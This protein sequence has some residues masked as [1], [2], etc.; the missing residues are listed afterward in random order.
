MA[1]YALVCGAGGFIGA[2][3]VRR[4]KREGYWVR[5]V[6]LAA[7]PHA[8]SAADEFVIAD[9]REPSACRD[10][11]DRRFDEV[12]QLAADM[13]GAGYVFAGTSDWDILSNS[14]Q[15]TLNVIQA[16]IATD[17]ERLFFA[18][19][20]C[21]YP[22]GNQSDI[23]NPVTR[24]DTAYP[25][26]PDSDYG[27]EKLYGE[28]LCLAAHRNRGLKVRI[29]RYHNVYGPEGTWRGGR[30]KVPAALC[31]KVAEA[32]DGS[33]IEIWGDGRQTRSFLFIDDCLEGTR[34]L[35]R[36][37]FIGPVNIGSPEAVTINEL[38]RMIMGI[39]GKRL[40]IIHKPG[41]EGV[42]ARVSDNDLAL[43]RL[44]WSPVQP[45]TQGLAVTYRWIARQVAQ[46]GGRATGFTGATDG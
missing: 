37:D 3:L 14:T 35:M 25:A 17:A 7:P 31:R 42:R 23:A 10:L 28:R 29:A 2:H 16:S 9:L 6:D 43:Q 36:S 39:A 11:F 27:F 8:P 22:R 5:G 15:I 19:S 30:E 26:D 33:T 38:A 18:S 41:P 13:G 12:Y 46:S 44:V 1:G 20:A 24:E 32:A 21:I 45:L 4:L 34:R 40:E